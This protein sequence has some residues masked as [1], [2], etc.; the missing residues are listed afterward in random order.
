MP[1]LIIWWLTGFKVG[2]DPGTVAWEWS[3]QPIPKRN[4]F[5]VFNSWVVIWI[6]YGQLITLTLII[7]RAR[8]R[9]WTDQSVIRLATGWCGAGISLFGFSSVIALMAND[10]ICVVV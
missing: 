10:V 4:S 1:Y 7:G 6:G 5:L 2:T 8:S 3:T 9:H